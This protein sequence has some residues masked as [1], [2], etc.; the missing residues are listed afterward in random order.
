MTLRHDPRV[1]RGRILAKATLSPAGV[2]TGGALAGIGLAAGIALPWVIAAAVGAWL[3]SAVL[4]LRDPKLIGALVAP[5]FGKDMTRL[6]GEY[7]RSM[8]AGLD[9]RARFEAA[10]AQLDEDDDDSLGSDDFGGMRVRIINALDR[11]YD[12]L[13][14][15]QRAGEFL[16][17][18]DPDGLQRRLLDLPK[19][20]PIARELEA[21][22]EE[23][24]DIDRKRREIVARSS[25]TITGIETLAIKVG[26][27]ALDVS[28]PGR[29]DH[30][31][32]IGAIRRELDGYLHGLEEIQSA[33]EI[34]PPSTG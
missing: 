33:L 9:A 14:W 8:V 34:L 17:S 22:L 26:S 5:D 29:H 28:A 3:T 23:A 16:A 31:D 7:R 10:T 1:R 27:L 13:V 12:S 11:L 25:T 2:V 15:A 4:H 30:L 21:Q 32:D 24:R 18:V 20:S 6:T 19:A